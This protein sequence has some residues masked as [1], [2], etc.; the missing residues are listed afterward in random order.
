MVA[1]LFL[2]IEH[3]AIDLQRPFENAPN[4]TP[5]TALSRTIEIDLKDMLGEK[6][7]PKPIVANN[8]VLI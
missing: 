5:M 3:M 6:D 1:F 7:L 4:D 2:T 8:G